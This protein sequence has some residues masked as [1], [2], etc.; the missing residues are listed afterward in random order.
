MKTICICYGSQNDMQ[1]VAGCL[2]MYGKRVRSPTGRLHVYVRHDR[3]AAANNRPNMLAKMQAC[4]GQLFVA[5]TINQTT[6]IQ[7]MPE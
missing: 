6:E 5:Q 7:H 4:A 3:H 1:V 2:T